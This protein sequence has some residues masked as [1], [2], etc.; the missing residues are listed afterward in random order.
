MDKKKLTETD[1]ITKFIMPAVVEK[2]RD[3]MTQIGQEVK[4]RD[5]NVIVHGQVA[6]RKKLSQKMLFFTQTQIHPAQPIS[7]EALA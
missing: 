7:Q 3:S 1:I 5:G 2:G 6:A 4:L